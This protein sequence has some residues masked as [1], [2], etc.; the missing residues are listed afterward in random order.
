[1]AAGHQLELGAGDEGC[2]LAAVGDGHK[3]VAPA[4]Q[5]ERWD[6]YVGETPSDVVAVAGFELA[7]YSVSAVPLGG[8]G[9]S[10]QQPGAPARANR[11]GGRRRA[12]GPVTAPDE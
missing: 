5:H 1:M 3:A 8:G 11:R 7:A 9:D 10:G 12:S 2:E 6:A 4:V